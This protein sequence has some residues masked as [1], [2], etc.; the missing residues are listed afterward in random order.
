MEVEKQ[1]FLGTDKLLPLIARFAIPSVIGMLV[2]ALYNIVDRIYVGNIPNEGGLAFAAISITYP[3]T[4]LIIA[5]GGLIRMGATSIMSI[6]LGQGDR[7]TA[8]KLINMSFLLF[9]VMGILYTIGIIAFLE[10]IIKLLGASEQTLPYAKDYMFIIALGAPFAFVGFGMNNFIYADGSPKVAMFSQ[11]IG[12]VLNIILDPI[13]IFTFNQGIKGAAI[14]TVI[15]QIISALYVTGY[16]FTKS[17]SFKLK[18]SQMGIKLKL[19]SRICVLGFPVFINQ[20]ANGALQAIINIQLGIHGNDFH[21]TAMGIVLSITQ[22]TMLPV[23]G[24]AHGIQPIVGYNYGAAKYKRVIDSYYIGVISGIIFISILYFFFMIWPQLF[25]NMFVGNSPVDIAFTA[26][27]IRIFLLLEPLIGLEIITAN[28]YMS[29]EKPIKSLMLNL[30]R[31]VFALIPLILILPNIFGLDGILFAGPIA[32]V[33]AIVA[34]VICIT[35]D[36]KK[37]KAKIP[38]EAF[39]Q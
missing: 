38:K 3:L 15:S 8:E 12:G 34:T 2:T 26:R 5:F 18:I 24:I 16:F 28:F 1:D 10:P 25:I 31:T 30:L 9:I 33:I 20:I 27:A 7:K 36:I 39:A 6:S 32:E 21:I 4:L 35:G 13:F 14:A 37:L 19:L 11:I 23:I 29:I 22:F 17:S